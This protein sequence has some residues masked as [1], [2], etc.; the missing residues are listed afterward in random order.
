MKILVV[1]YSGS[2]KS[3]FTKRI[4]KLNKIPRLHIDRIFFEPNWVERDWSIVEK[5]IR[6]FMRNESWII[7][8]KYSNL[9]KDRYDECDVIFIFDYNRF[10]CLYGAIIRRIKYHN[11]QRDTIA[12]GCRERLNFSF[13]WWILFQGR[14]KKEK[15]LL[16]N[17]QKKYPAKVI[18]F[19]N[20]KQTNKYLKKTGYKGSLKPE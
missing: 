6:E 17:L 8:G 18:V 3:T 11:K 13:V 15:L 10:K 9:A 16:K 4:S 1:G 7:D 20:R 12:E 2:G 14:K 19:K 5:E